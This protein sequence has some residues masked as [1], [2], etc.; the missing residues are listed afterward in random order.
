MLGLLEY[1]APTRSMLHRRLRRGIVFAIFLVGLSSSW[2]D[3]VEADPFARVLL[4]EQPPVAGG[5]SLLSN[6]GE[7]TVA[8]DWVATS[9]LPLGAV[10]WWGT[11]AG[12]P[13]NLPAKDFFLSQI[14]TD[15]GGLPGGINFGTFDPNNVTRTATGLFDGEGRPL[16]QFDAPLGFDIPQVVGHRYWLNLFDG[17]FGVV[18]NQFLWAQGGSGNRTEAVANDASFLFRQADSDR[19]FELFFVP[20][21][22]AF[23][24]LFL[25]LVAL[26]GMVEWRKHRGR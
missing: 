12:D 1:Q 9:S 20:E 26:T 14:L 11:Y 21:P 24:L 10:R 2:G 23:V 18:A 25:G 4:Y 3:R 7:Q 15:S 8:D 5:T 22:S 13:N 19:A 16:F 6:Y 17:S